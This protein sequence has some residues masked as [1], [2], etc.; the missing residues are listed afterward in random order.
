MDREDRGKS[1]H[2]DPMHTHDIRE[3]PGSNERY[4]EH[5]REHSR[6]GAHSHGS[7]RTGNERPDFDTVKNRKLE[8]TMQA[9]QN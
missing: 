2:Q 8:T 3:H 6:C 1:L 4:R 9:D 7:Q 5:G